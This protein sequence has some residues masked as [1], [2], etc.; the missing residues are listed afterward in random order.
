LEVL[1]DDTLAGADKAKNPV[2]ADALAADFSSGRFSTLSALRSAGY[3]VYVNGK[4]VTSG[5][6]MIQPNDTVR[7]M[8]PAGGD[9]DYGDDDYGD[10]E[11]GVPTAISDG[12][13]TNAELLVGTW[14]DS[15][16][17]TSVT[18]TSNGEYQQSPY[19]NGTY[20]ATETTFTVDTGEEVFSFTVPAVYEIRNFAGTTC[21]EIQPIRAN[22]LFRKDLALLVR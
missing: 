8:A 19:A 11:G 3:K 7:V 9:D 16:S 12:G 14:H 13:Q 1:F 6:T 4:E 2:S 22:S 5:S 18:F 21:I 17:N 10:D 15:K 20:T